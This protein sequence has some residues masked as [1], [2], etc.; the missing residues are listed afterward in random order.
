MQ[1]AVA[2]L[3]G[4]CSFRALARNFDGLNDV[5]GGKPWFLDYARGSMDL[6]VSW[7]KKYAVSLDTELVLTSTLVP[8]MLKSY[9]EY[10]QDE[11]SRVLGGT[12]PEKLTVSAMHMFVSHRGGVAGGSVACCQSSRS[13][14]QSNSRSTIRE[15]AFDPTILSNLIVNPLG[16]TAIV[17]AQCRYRFCRVSQLVGDTWEPCQKQGIKK[18]D[19]FC[20]IHYNIL[21]TLDKNNSK[22]WKP[23]GREYTADDFKLLTEGTKK[24]NGNNRCCRVCEKN[25]DDDDFV[26]CDKIAQGGK[27]GCCT[28]HHSLVT[29]LGLLSKKKKEEDYTADDFK[30]LTKCKKHSDGKNR[31]CRVCE[32]ND[33]GD[34]V[35]CDKYGKEDGCCRRHYG[36]LTTLGLI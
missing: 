30:L 29:K 9:A 1:V 34:F 4:D 25:D 16:S 15:G 10:F 13:S 2:H 26:P 11:I 24:G 6:I 23:Q 21:S 31:F 7:L 17:S 14:R 3:N 33:D 32:K 22:K 18:C 36:L 5:N 27:D 20:T 19:G 8:G 35:P 28:G 12:R